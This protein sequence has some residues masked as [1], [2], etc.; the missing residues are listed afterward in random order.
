LFILFINNTIISIDFV[1]H[2]KNKLIS[3]INNTDNAKIGTSLLY[4]LDKASVLLNNFFEKQKNSAIQDIQYKALTANELIQMYE[5][6]QMPDFC[7]IEKLKDSGISEYT[8]CS[9]GVVGY[10]IPDKPVDGGMDMFGGSGG[11]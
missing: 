4:E 9:S 8:I 2:L 5:N 11:Y 1:E 6:N 10:I 3:I 7:I